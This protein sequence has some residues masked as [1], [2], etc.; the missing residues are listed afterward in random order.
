MI[1]AI[2]LGIIILFSSCRVML[3]GMYGLFVI[4]VVI[5]KRKQLN[6]LR[7]TNTYL[8]IFYTIKY[9]KYMNEEYAV[10]RKDK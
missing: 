7:F 4:A 10:R 6:I 3:K 8:P 1:A 5:I 2:V 9:K